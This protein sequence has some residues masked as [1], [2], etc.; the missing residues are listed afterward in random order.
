[1]NLTEMSGESI[2]SGGEDGNGRIYMSFHDATMDHSTGIK[3]VANIYRII[4]DK[5]DLATLGLIAGGGQ[6]N[7]YLVTVECDGV[8]DH[9]LGHANQISMFA[10][11]LV[12]NMDNLVA[13]CGCLGLSY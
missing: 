10:L 6:P 4:R 2:F 7:N 9:N 1:M 8:P 11:F 3:H 12:V 13:T 5:A